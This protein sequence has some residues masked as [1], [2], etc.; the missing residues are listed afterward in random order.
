MFK[1]YSNSKTLHALGRYGFGTCC[2]VAGLYLVGTGV[3][4]VLK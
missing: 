2:I 1:T 3:A 4:V